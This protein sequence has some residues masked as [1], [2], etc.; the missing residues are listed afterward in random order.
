MILTNTQATFAVLLKNVDLIIKANIDS[1]PV[2]IN[3][4]KDRYFDGEQLEANEL[5][6]IMNYDAQRLQ[7]LNAAVNDRDFEK[8]YLEMQAKANLAPFQDFI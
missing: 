8:R 2:S 1:F 6:A 4:L 7:Y 3:D 5:K